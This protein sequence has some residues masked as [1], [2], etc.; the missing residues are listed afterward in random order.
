M[1]TTIDTNNLAALAAAPA[2]AEANKAKNGSWFQAMADAWGKTLDAQAD[3]IQDLSTRVSA[4]ED[5]PSN[6]SAMSVETLRFGYLTTSS[7]TAITSAG[8]GLKSMASKS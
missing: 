4:G 8:E 5:K 2:A 1:A 3:T 6:L 7:H